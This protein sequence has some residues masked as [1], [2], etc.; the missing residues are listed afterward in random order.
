MSVPHPSPKSLI[1]IY[2]VS[3]LIWEH[4]RGWNKQYILSLVGTLKKEMLPMTVNHRPQFES[5]V[6]FKSG[7]YGLDS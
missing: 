4:D 6:L 7:C 1:A 3:L 5:G 2:W